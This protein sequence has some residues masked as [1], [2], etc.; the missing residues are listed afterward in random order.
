MLRGQLPSQQGHPRIDAPD[1]SARADFP[2]DVAEQVRSDRH[3][4][5]REIHGIRRAVGIG[6]R[7]RLQ[8]H[9][10]DTEPRQSID[11]VIDVA[12][13]LLWIRIVDVIKIDVGDLLWA[14]VFRKAAAANVDRIAQIANVHLRLDQNTAQAR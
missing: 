3:M 14:I 13:L 8:I 6:I 12:A 2:G 7:K 11:Q 1:R 9:G 10:V 5:V 4:S